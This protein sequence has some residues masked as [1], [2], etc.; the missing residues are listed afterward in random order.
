MGCILPFKD[1][2]LQP[3]GSFWLV[4]KICL[5]TRLLVFLS[6]HVLLTSTSVPLLRLSSCLGY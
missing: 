1:S 5:L 3:N 6:P 4:L 2:V